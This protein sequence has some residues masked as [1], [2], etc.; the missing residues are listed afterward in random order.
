MESQMISFPKEIILRAREKETTE[1]IL[2]SC[3]I[4]QI[5]IFLPKQKFQ[6]KLVASKNVYHTL[7]LGGVG[8]VDIS[9][10]LECLASVHL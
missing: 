4:N 5:Y 2:W 1:V 3:Y 8:K 6:N 10:S 9:V 7:K